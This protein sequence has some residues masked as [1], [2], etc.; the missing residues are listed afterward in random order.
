MMVI[1]MGPIGATLFWI[2]L[3]GAAYDGYPALAFGYSKMFVGAVHQ[4]FPSR[5][6]RFEDPNTDPIMRWIQ[7]PVLLILPLIFSLPIAPNFI[8]LTVFANAIAVVLIPAIVVGI[9]WITNKKEWLLPGWAN[10]WW[11]NVIIIA[12]GGV[13]IWATFNLIRSFF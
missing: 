13:G 9:V 11:E 4:T 12:V 3:L 7:I 5:K 2:G 1:V 8:V 10:S 6:A